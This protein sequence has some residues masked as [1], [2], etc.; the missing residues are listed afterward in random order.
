MSIPIY[1]FHSHGFKLWVAF[2][3]GWWPILSRRMDIV[4]I[5]RRNLENG[6]TLKHN[7]MCKVPCK[8]DRQW[9]SVAE[10]NHDHG[11]DA[12]ALSQELH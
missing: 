1:R 8:F 10:L 12:T 6:G 3:E 4:T 2:M 9:I 11:R 5:G 7:N